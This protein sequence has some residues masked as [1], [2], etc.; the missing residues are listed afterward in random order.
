MRLVSNRGLLWVMLL[1]WGTMD[2]QVIDNTWSFKNIS[3][4]RYLRFNYE[5]DFYAARDKYYTQGIHAEIVSAGLK[6]NPLSYLL[7]RPAG[8]YT[9][10][11]L[12]VVQEGY[13]PTYIDHPEVLVGDRPYAAC[14]YLKT[15]QLS[16]DTVRKQRFS[17]TLSTGVIGPAALGAE[18]QTGIH[19]ALD[20]VMPVGWPNQIHND[21]ILNYQVNYERQLVSTGKSFM[22]D[23]DA[24]GRVGTLSDKASVGI[25]LMAGYFES[26]Y[27]AA[28]ARGKNFRIYAYEHPEVC[29][30]AYDATLQGGVFNRKSVYTISS[31]DIN[32]VTLQNRFGF[33]LTYRRMCLEYF[34]SYVSREFRTGDYHAWGGVQLGIGL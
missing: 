11:G 17:T 18:M 10:F 2:A 34:Q 29:F 28:V 27:G 31:S 12:G 33:V 14:L 6:Y 15:F 25:T 16:I 30:V 24:M 4:D 23:A 8:W 3:A 7:V 22:L 20:N 13:T 9:R 5:N 1:T 21:I 32:R 26:P 19:R